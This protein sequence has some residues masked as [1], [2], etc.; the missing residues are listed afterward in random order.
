MQYRIWESEC[1]LTENDCKALFFLFFCNEQIFIFYRYKFWCF[2]TDGGM[3]VV[4]LYFV[5]KSLKLP[6]PH[7]LFILSFFFWICASAKSFVSKKMV[8][9]FKYSAISAIDYLTGFFMIRFNRE[10]KAKRGYFICP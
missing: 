2:C 9:L 10:T 8:P 1:A 5:I 3:D 6:Y 7:S 4:F